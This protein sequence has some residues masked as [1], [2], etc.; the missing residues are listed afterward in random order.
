M[1]ERQEW[2]KI[3]DTLVLN[4]AR[5]EKAVPSDA[6]TIETQEEPHEDLRAWRDRDPERLDER[7]RRRTGWAH[8]CRSPG[9]GLRGTYL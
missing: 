6:L 2:C 7:V 5:L 8:V 1:G 4:S 9:R 3:C